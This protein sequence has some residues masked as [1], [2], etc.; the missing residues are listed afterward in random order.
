MFEYLNAAVE[1][2]LSMEASTS[3]LYF[4]AEGPAGLK[5]SAHFSPK[6]TGKNSLYTMDCT[7]ATNLRRA[8]WKQ[9]S[10]N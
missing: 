1:K 9:N 2:A 6:T 7:M 8:S 5:E 4:V 3:G 10:I